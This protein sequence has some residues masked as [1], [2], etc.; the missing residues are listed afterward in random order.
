MKSDIFCKPDGKFNKTARTSGQ[1]P[2]V[3]TAFCCRSQAFLVEK[4]SY[5]K[6]KKKIENFE[7][8]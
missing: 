1:A 8:F 3:S 5:E 4:R 6:F 7:F 2:N